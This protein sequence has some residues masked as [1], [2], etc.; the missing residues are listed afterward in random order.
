MKIITLEEKH[1][2][3]DLYFNKA[4]NITQI[5]QKVNISRLKVSEIVKKYK[6][7]NNIDVACNTIIKGFI[8]NIPPRFLKDI[9][10]EGE[11]VKICVDKNKK[12]IIL[13]K[14]SRKV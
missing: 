5:S 13:K 2:V 10:V 11:K 12:Q 4:Y 9:G 8:I 6:D 7:E 3:I 1:K 14:K